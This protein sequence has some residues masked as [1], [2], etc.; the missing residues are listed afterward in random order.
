MSTEA[1]NSLNDLQ[2]GMELRGKVTNIEL[3]G[4]FVDIGI[5]QSALLHISQLGQP[6]IRNVEDVVKVG[7]EIPVYVLK[8]DKAAGRVAL[9][10]VKPAAWIKATR[11]A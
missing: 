1:P 2:V 4:A 8:V 5:S 7:D 9:S 3:F 11:C 10:L 6:N